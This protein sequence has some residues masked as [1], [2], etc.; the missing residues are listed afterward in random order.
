ML[1]LQIHNCGRL[2]N[3][4]LISYRN[5]FTVGFNIFLSIDSM[6]LDASCLTGHLL[7]QHIIFPVR[8]QLRTLWIFHQSSTITKFDI[9]LIEIDFKD[10]RHSEL[11]FYHI[12]I[13]WIFNCILDCHL[14][15]IQNGDRF[16]NVILNKKIRSY[17][18]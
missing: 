13:C 7:V 14:S 18:K 8:K 11:F 17:S 15:G 12:T 10:I 16:C 5:N 2:I 9:E 6:A 3:P 1:C 4:C